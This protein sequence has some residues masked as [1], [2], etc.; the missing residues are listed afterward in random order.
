MTQSVLKIVLGLTLAVGP[1]VAMS[2]NNTLELVGLGLLCPIKQGWAVINRVDK[3]LYP[4][5]VEK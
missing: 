2:Q 4:A 1:L 3:S 5:A